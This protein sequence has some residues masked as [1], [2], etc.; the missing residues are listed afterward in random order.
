MHNIFFFI[1]PVLLLHE[2][3][4]FFKWI[5]QET[6]KRTR[7]IYR[8]EYVMFLQK[9]RLS[10]TY[11]EN[12]WSPLKISWICC[13]TV[14]LVIIIKLIW[15]NSTQINS[16]TFIPLMKIALRCLSDICHFV[17]KKRRKTLILK[18]YSKICISNSERLHAGN[19]IHISSFKII[20]NT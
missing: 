14:A 17:L 7:D 5:E 19:S 11:E 9:V 12:Y 16:E 20:T 10:F 4:Y 13:K 6:H 3:D 2:V 8:Y 1:C 18:E 15:R